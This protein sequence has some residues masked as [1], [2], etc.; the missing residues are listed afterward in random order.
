MEKNCP[1]CERHCPENDLGCRRGRE[2][3]GGEGNS[4]GAHGARESHGPH[5]SHGPRESR[6]EEKALA[7]LRKCGHFL[8]HSGDTA[9]NPAQLLSVLTEEERTRLETLLEKCLN[10]W[11]K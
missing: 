9:G 5:G 7:L 4:R 6:P 3:F 8:H 2:H 11:Q 10:S 1:C